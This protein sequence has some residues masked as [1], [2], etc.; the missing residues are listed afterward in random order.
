MVFLYSFQLPIA[1]LK[2]AGGMKLETKTF[3]IIMKE[4]ADKNNILIQK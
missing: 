4:L 1:S 3:T 2:S